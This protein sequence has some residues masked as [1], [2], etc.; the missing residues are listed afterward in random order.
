[1]AALRS[2]EG[3][4]ESEGGPERK[5]PADAVAREIRVTLGQIPAEIREILQM[6]KVFGQ[7]EISQQLTEQLRARL[8]PSGFKVRQ[9]TQCTAEDLGVKPPSDAVVSPAFCLAARVLARRS[10]EL[11]FLPPKVSPWQQ[12][13]TR[14]SSGKL[15]W[16][17]GA[18]A[19]VALLVG[20]VFFYQY[21]R[22]SQLQTR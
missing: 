22:L 14:Y 2:L 3:A 16:A 13:A 4:V 5:L 12:F 1:M 17:G 6:V 21:W 10:P 7:G 8:E 18:A 15:A 20:G 11:E 19:G 9:L